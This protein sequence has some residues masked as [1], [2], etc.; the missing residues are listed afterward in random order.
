M[1]C[2]GSEQTGTALT[3]AVLWNSSPEP[4]PTPGTGDS[5]EQHLVAQSESAMGFSCWEKS[6]EMPPTSFVG[7]SQEGILGITKGWM[8]EALTR[9]CQTSL[10]R[11]GKTRAQHPRKL[12]GMEFCASKGMK[13]MEKPWVLLEGRGPSALP[14]AQR[15]DSLWEMEMQPRPEPSTEPPR[16]SPKPRLSPGALPLVSLL[17]C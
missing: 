17:L 5:Q 9:P 11:V 10:S 8:Q 16:A 2:K 12:P 1:F 4:L 14:T 13:A 6:E 7:I 15:R 3:S